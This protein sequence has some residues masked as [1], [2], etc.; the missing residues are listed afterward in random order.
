M[1][2]KLLIPRQ[3]Y[4]ILLS[5]QYLKKVVLD[6]GISHF[7]EC[8]ISDGVSEIPT[9]V[10]GGC[11][12]VMF[13]WNKDL[14]EMGADVIGTPLR[15]HAIGVHVGCH[16][17]GVRFLPGEPFVFEP[18]A[19]SELI[20]RTV[21]LSDTAENRLLI[22]KI[23]TAQNFEARIEVFMKDSLIDH[24]HVIDNCFSIQQLRSDTTLYTQVSSKEMF[25][26]FI[27]GAI[28]EAQAKGNVLIGYYFEEGDSVAIIY[29]Y[30]ETSE[31]RMFLKDRKLQKVWT[32]KSSGTMYPLN[33]I[34]NDR[35][36]LPGFAW[37]NYVR[38]MNRYDIFNW[39]E[40]KSVEN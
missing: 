34:P 13:Y 22:E 29:N 30:Q 36:H 35:K 32:P 39:R 12:D 25:A 6:Y 31:L 8:C 20:E 23:A 33:Q 10:P 4:Q 9:S 7:Y 26:Y 11:I 37:Y 1:E 2:T 40:K 3:P 16:Y 5:E 19:F 14:S 17:F 27:D 28:H 38:P 18:L 21:P 15:P 24:A